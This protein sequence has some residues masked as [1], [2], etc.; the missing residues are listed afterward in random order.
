MELDVG[1]AVLLGPGDGERLNE[2]IV[3]KLE[4]PEISV[5]EVNVRSPREGAGPHYHKE[6]VD[7]FYV[8]EGE[9]E[10][11]N[12]T[13]TLRAGPGTSVAVPP[14]IVHGFRITGD[15]GARY[16]NIH[17]PDRDFIEYLRHAISGESFEWD[18][19]DVDEPYGPTDAIVV[20]PE[21]NER[22]VRSSSMANTIRAE[23]TELSLFEMEIDLGWEG[24]SPHSHHDHVDSFYVLD[25]EVEFLKD[26]EDVRVGAGTFFAAPLHIEH[27]F[28]P[29]GPAR[30]FNLHAPDAGFAGRLRSR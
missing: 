28:R 6:H 7:A 9:I 4:L 11:I 1:Q 27:G 13:E 18:S 25:G 22:L 19:V 24:V 16:L 23:T 14:G 15:R 5:N 8:L 20:G 21:G 30:I 10:F 26:G 17:A 3:V 29:V 12:G 2:R